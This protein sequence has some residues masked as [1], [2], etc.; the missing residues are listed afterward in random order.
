MIRKLGDCQTAGLAKCCV[1]E[2]LSRVRRIVDAFHRSALGSALPN[3]RVAAPVQNSND[4]DPTRLSSIE[5][6]KRE[7]TQER[8]SH[9]PMHEAVR[10]RALGNGREHDLGF[11]KK[12]PP[13]S[14]AL[15]LI[16]AR[17]VR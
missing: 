2:H 17:R 5:H 6:A 1:P 16:P 13:E 9:S 10:K 3:L 14:W 8:T 7:A 12:L 15:L 11:V 4:Y